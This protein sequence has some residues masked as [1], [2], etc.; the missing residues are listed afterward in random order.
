MLS[1]FNYL[2]QRHDG[3]LRG[4]LR[5]L[6]DDA[7]VADDGSDEALYVKAVDIVARERRA[8]TSFVQRR[9]QIGY[10]R[11]ARLVE[12]M[13]EAGVVSPANRVGKRE[14]LIGEPS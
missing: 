8:S 5:R 13:E 12:M 1:D 7:A 4:Y 11:A 10:N 3:P 2:V 14:V 9:L 6:V